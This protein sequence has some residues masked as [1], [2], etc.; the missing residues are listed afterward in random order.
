M[1]TTVN[2]ELNGSKALPQPVNNG[3]KQFTQLHKNFDN[4]SKTFYD[5]I[6]GKISEIINDRANYSE[7]C[8]DWDFNRFTELVEGVLN[9]GFNNDSRTRIW[10]AHYLFPYPEPKGFKNPLTFDK[11]DEKARRQIRQLLALA[12][13]VG[14]IEAQFSNAFYHLEQEGFP[15]SN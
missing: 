4:G 13:Q 3:F 11:M 12:E 6:Y 15:A 14:E 8:E 9:F 5:A 10:S 1:Q 7:F 2:K